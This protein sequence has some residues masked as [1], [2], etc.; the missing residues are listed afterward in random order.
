LVLS[1]LSNACGSAPAEM[2]P[3]RPA[4]EE[5]AAF[6]QQRPA[7]QAQVVA[8][9]SQPV[10]TL[11]TPYSRAEAIEVLDDYFAAIGRESNTDLAALL[12]EDATMRYGLGSAGGLALVAWVRRFAQRDYLTPSPSSVYDPDG[13]ELHAARDLDQRLPGDGMAFTPEA[14]ELLLRVPLTPTAARSRFGN[15]LQLLLVPGE[16]GLVIRKIFERG[17]ADP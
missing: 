15:E 13:L 16:R 11:R 10:V 7:P 4:P 12:T 6:V 1:T 8:D 3:K 2:T 14:S 17:Y 5:R 9:V